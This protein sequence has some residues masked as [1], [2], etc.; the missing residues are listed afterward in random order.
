MLTR[1]RACEQLQ[2]FGEH[3]QASTRLNFASKSSKGKILR[4]VK[5]F[6]GPFITPFIVPRAKIVFFSRLCRSYLR[7][8]ADTEDSRHTQDNNLW[9]PGYQSD[10][11]ENLCLNKRRQDK[12]RNWLITL[13]KTKYITICDFTDY[14][15]RWVFSSDIFEEDMKNSATFFWIDLLQTFLKP[16]TSR[17]QCFSS[18]QLVN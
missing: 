5:N 12:I 18:L 10:K 14:K 13:L 16:F 2:K 3:E 11:G 15:H 4:A 8:L 9:Y 6:H 17:L 7:P 1:K